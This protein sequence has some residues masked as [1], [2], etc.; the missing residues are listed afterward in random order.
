MF[1]REMELRHVRL[2]L[3]NGVNSLAQLPDA[4]A[5]DDAH[6]QN[7]ARPTLRQIFHHERLHFARLKRVQVQHAINRQLDGF[8]VHKVIQARRRSLIHAD[9][10]F[11]I[12][13]QVFQ[14]PPL[15][16]VE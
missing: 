8:V 16:R 7:P 12:L 15:P 11:L 14:F 9:S 2:L 1:T 4:F 3:Q 6:A 5:V 10:V 13:D